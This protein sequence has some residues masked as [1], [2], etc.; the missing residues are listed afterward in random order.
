MSNLN[1]LMRIVNAFLPNH[2]ISYAGDYYKNDC[3]VNILTAGCFLLL[4]DANNVPADRLFP[5]FL[6][7]LGEFY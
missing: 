6:I 1:I 4:I 5:I 2:P 7:L 3:Y